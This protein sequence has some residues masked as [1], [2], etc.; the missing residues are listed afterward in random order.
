VLLLLLLSVLVVV[1]WRAQR[2][3]A[4]GHRV[5]WVEHVAEHA[6]AAHGSKAKVEPRAVCRW[7]WWWDVVVVVVGCDDHG[8]D[9]G[10]SW[11]WS[12][13]SLSPLVCDL[14]LFV[15]S[16]RTQSSLLSFTITTTASDLHQQQRQHQHQPSSAV[17][18]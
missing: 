10:V 14:R 18:K 7:W 3:K 2:F 4:V 17:F 15:S 11:R 5:V 9:V 1:A 12:C 6:S 13:F 8:F 16:S